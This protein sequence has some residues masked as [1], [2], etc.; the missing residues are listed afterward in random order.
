MSILAMTCSV[1]HG[2]RFPWVLV[3]EFV[4]G[5]HGMWARMLVANVN[6]AGTALEWCVVDD[7]GTPPADLAAWSLLRAASCVRLR[8]GKVHYE[9]FNVNWGRA[10]F[11]KCNVA[12]VVGANGTF[13]M[14]F[15]HC[16]G[17]QNDVVVITCSYGD[18]TAVAK[19][20]CSSAQGLGCGQAVVAS[21][22]CIAL[23]WFERVQLD[24]AR[25]PRI[26]PQAGEP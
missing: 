12:S 9:L 25:C 10:S 19:V 11:P 15:G 6:P 18:V 7:D 4:F 14:R 26:L 3:D 1:L 16:R 8:A 24:P 13:E 5:C 20:K 21:P 22:L 17:Q 2:N 23:P